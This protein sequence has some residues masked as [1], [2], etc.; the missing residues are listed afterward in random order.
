VG[1]LIIEQHVLSSLLKYSGKGRDS[2]KSVE[3]ENPVYHCAHLARGGGIPTAQRPSL[4]DIPL[5]KSR[6]Y[7]VTRV[8]GN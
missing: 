7:T 3:Q 1:T 5:W 6:G 4:I 8:V 2:G